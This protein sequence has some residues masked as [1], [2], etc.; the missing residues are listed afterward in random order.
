M[1]KRPTKCNLCGG[2]VKFVSNAEIYGRQ[3]GSG[4]AYL[5]TK[6][7]AYTGTHKPRPKDALGLLANSEMR[8]LKIECHDLFDAQWNTYEERCEMYKWLANQM[9]ISVKECH[10][11][12]FDIERLRKAKQIL[13]QAEKKDE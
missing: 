5:C 7:G 8:K 11:G 3:Y 12:H 10:F 4:Y 1:N 9:D 2:M 6:C 13:E